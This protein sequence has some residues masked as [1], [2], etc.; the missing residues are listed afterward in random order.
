MAVGRM[1]SASRAPTRGCVLPGD[2]RDRGDAQA[3]L[4]RW[5]SSPGAVMVVLT[6]TYL[7]GADAAPTLA[8][9]EIRRCDPP[10]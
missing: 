5:R 2:R 6:L 7:A 3:R 1:G 4:P 9:V 10:R 8:V